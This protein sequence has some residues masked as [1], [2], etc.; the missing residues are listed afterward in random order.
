MTGSPT[1]QFLLM[2]R[3]GR[4]CADTAE[5]ANNLAPP[6][7]YLHSPPQLMCDLCINAATVGSRFRRRNWLPFALPL[8]RQTVFIE[9]ND[10]AV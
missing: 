5:A 3:E 7:G 6:A 2:A 4:L 9:R 10:F 8:T 1:L